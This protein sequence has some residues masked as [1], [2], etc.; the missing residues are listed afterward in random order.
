[1]GGQGERPVSCLLLPVAA[2]GGV[3][4]Q[5]FGILVARA[6][7]VRRTTGWVGPD[8]ASVVAWAA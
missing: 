6:P 3:A 8:G 4:D 2:Q 7:N 1:M 5:V